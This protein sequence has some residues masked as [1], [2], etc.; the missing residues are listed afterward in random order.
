MTQKQSTPDIQHELA[1]TD[2]RIRSYLIWEREGR[3]DGQAQQHWLR[4]ISELQDELPL[5]AGD[6]KKSGKKSSKSSAHSIF[7]ARSSK[8]AVR[9]ASSSHAQGNA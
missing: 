4:A 7:G 9:K 8:S 2:I 3:P 1:E 5:G 6:S